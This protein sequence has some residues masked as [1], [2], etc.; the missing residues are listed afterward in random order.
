MNKDFNTSKFVGTT[1]WISLLIIIF[2]LVSG[3]FESNFDT[4]F[5]FVFLSVVGVLN[6]L[7]E[8][9]ERHKK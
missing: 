7:I 3:V 2:G 9:S 6:A 1:V 4:W 5:C 8:I